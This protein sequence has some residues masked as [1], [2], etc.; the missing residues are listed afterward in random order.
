MLAHSSFNHLI[1]MSYVLP[2]ILMSSVYYRSSN[3]NSYYLLYQLMQSLHNL[4]ARRILVAG[5][6][7][8]GCLPLQMTLAALRLS[9]RPQGCI[10]EQNAAAESYNAKLQRMLTKFQSGS[11]G[12]KAVYVDIYSPL[13]DMVDQPQKYGE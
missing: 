8:V 2:L 10:A 9:P 4:G 1:S 7:P 6:P 5:L 3:L 12:T 13:M 11:P